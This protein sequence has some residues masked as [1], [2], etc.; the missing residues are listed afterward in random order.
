MSRTFNDVIGDMEQHVIDL[1]EK[2]EDPHQPYPI[3]R[4]DAVLALKSMNE[5][6]KQSGQE[7]SDLAYA[8]RKAQDGDMSAVAR[9][10]N[11]DLY[12]MGIKLK[13]DW[14]Q[15]EKLSAVSMDILK[16]HIAGF[17]NDPESHVAF[18]DGRHYVASVVDYR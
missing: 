6:F 8:L 5:H 17:G 9:L 13:P 16:R 11:G 12:L 2:G 15:R 14:G 18:H 3:S 1:Q 4:E 10:L 7:S